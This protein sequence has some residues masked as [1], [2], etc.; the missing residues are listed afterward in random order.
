M[1]RILGDADAEQGSLGR[2]H[3]GR[4]ELGGGHLAEPLEAADLDFASALEMMRQQ[5][6]AMGV[7]A[8]VGADRPLGQAIERRRREIQLAIVDQRRHFQVEKGHQQGG[9]MGAVHIGVGHDDDAFI[10]Q[11]VAVILAAGAAAEG[12]NQIA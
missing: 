5:L 3:G 8:G 4:L 9:D 1:A 11:G 2:V 7:V 6:V 12:Q 10:A